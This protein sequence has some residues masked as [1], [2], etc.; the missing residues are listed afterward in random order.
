MEAP[1][2]LNGNDENVAILMECE[3]EKVTIHY[4]KSWKEHISQVD[5]YRKDHKKTIPW[6]T[7]RHAH[8]TTVCGNTIE[9]HRYALGINLRM[10]SVDN[11]NFTG[12]FADKSCL[13]Q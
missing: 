9:F 2:P 12:M 1:I 6:G 7:L 8:T 4:K 11:F 10:K 13:S 3:N 5:I